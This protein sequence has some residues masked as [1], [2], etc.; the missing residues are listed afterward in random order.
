MLDQ[1][2]DKLGEV[3]DDKFVQKID[4]AVAEQP[5][6]EYPK[7]VY[8]HPE[9]KKREH[10]YVVVNS[11]EERDKAFGNGY[12]EKPHVP[13]IDEFDKNPTGNPANVAV[14]Q[15]S[16]TKI[17]QGETLLSPKDQPEQLDEPEKKDDES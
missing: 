13:Q 16:P 17:I 8:K 1:N 4:C 3:Q 15:D 12:E 5:I 7:M 2:E 11:D 14:R 10:I 6:E 9:D